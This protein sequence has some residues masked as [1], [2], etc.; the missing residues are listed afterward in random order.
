MPIES[1]VK[2]DGDGMHN[3]KKNVIQGKAGVD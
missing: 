3:G 1:R 2:E